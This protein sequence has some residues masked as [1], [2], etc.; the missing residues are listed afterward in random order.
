[1]DI[2]VLLRKKRKLLNLLLKINQLQRINQIR[3]KEKKRK[4]VWIRACILGREIRG[5]ASILVQEMHLRNVVWYYNYT[6]MM[7]DSFDELLHLIESIIQKQETNCR[8]PIPP[9][10]RLLITLRYVDIIY[11]YVFYPISEIYFYLYI[12]FYFCNV[13]IYLQILSVW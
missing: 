11:Y 1:M 4:R 10:I 2:S 9:A 5:E 3:N 7:L 12:Y 8:K 13:N 6:R